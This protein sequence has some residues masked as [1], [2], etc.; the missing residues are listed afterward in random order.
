[1]LKNITKGMYD[2]LKALLPFIIVYFIVSFSEKNRFVPNIGVE[3]WLLGVILSTIVLFVIFKVFF[4]TDESKTV[5]DSKSLVIVSVALIC[6]LLIYHFQN[7]FGLYAESENEMKLDQKISGNKESLHYL[8]VDMVIV[9]PVIEEITLRGVVY[10]YIKEACKSV[11]KW[12]TWKIK[13]S[14]I[15]HTFNIL[16]VIISTSLFTFIHSWDSYIEAIPYFSMGIVLSLVLIITKNILNT[17]CIHML[18][19]FFAFLDVGLYQCFL[20]CSILFIVSVALFVYSNKSNKKL[21][22]ALLK[23]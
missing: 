10:Y 18:N 8:F 13:N 1:M 20:L 9:A 3:K 7:I 22:K 2:A 23:H 4:F 15:N 16:F 21:K 6:I 14:F 17:I 12:N 19:N 5:F 11:I